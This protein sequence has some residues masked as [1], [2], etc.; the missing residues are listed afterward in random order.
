MKQISHKILPF[1]SILFFTFLFQP[2]A[3]GQLG[4]SFHQ[5]AY[6]AIGVHYEIKDFV[7][8]DGRIISDVIIE[9]LSIELLG[10][11][12]LIREEDYE[13]YTGI[14]YG[15]SSL[16]EFIGV[17]IPIGIIIYPLEYKNFGFH[18]ELNPLITEDLDSRLVVRGNWGLRYQF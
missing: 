17:I 2:T 16:P 13:F 15:L 8:L 4:V 12:K 3:K 5:S 18:I 11:A 9:D 1:F 7:M 10:L 14:G 6:T